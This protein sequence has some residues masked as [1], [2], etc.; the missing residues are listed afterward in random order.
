M[1]KKKSRLC[2][3]T[4]K[5]QGWV[6]CGI[7]AMVSIACLWM[8]ASHIPSADFCK[9]EGEAQPTRV[10]KMLSRGNL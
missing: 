3:G 2:I 6:G 9:L 4:A 7:P 1:K 5:R 10:R 8:K